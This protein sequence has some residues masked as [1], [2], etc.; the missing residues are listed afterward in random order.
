[1]SELGE[2]TSGLF[3]ERIHSIRE[4][5]GDFP[6]RLENAQAKKDAMDKLESLEQIIE[7]EL[8]SQLCLCIILPHLLVL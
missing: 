3:A 5:L 7:K 4:T 2:R 6:D 8:F 1:M